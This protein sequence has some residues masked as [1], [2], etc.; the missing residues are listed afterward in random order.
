VCPEPAGERLEIEKT[1]G[2]LDMVNYLGILHD[3]RMDAEISL[4]CWT[5]LLL[6][7]VA[8]SIP[9]L[10]VHD[11]GVFKIRIRPDKGRA[12]FIMRA[13]K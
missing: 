5:L 12:G 1:M 2:E 3:Q 13:K 4:R 9:P 7:S 6:R 11:S 10:P 8:S